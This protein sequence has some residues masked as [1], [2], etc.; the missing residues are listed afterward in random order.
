MDTMDFMD[1]HGYDGFFNKVSLNTFDTNF[2]H[3]RKNPKNFH[4]LFSTRISEVWVDFRERGATP[5]HD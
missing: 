2:P 3:G 1:I 4:R 5:D